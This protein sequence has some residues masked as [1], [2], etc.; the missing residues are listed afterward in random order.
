VSSFGIKFSVIYP[1]HGRNTAAISQTWYT[2]LSC[3][4]FLAGGPCLDSPLPTESAVCF[5]LCC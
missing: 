2:R 3:H 1:F 5:P 4:P